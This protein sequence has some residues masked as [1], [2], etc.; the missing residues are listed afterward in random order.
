MAAEDNSFELGQLTEAINVLSK[1][2]DSFEKTVNDKF[3]KIDERLRNYS[4]YHPTRR[5]FDDLKNRVEDAESEAHEAKMA[6]SRYS[7]WEKILT[8]IV[9][10]AVLLVLGLK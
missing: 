5:E 10:G 3:D 9:I 7:I 6:T 2:F 4:E 8:A 1:R